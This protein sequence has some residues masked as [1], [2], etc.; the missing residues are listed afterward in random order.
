MTESVTPIV[1]WGEMNYSQHPV[2]GKSAVQNQTECTPSLTNACIVCLRLTFG[3]CIRYY[4]C[5][6]QR[7]GIF[8][9]ANSAQNNDSWNGILGHYQ[10]LNG[11][12][13]GDWE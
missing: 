2:R 10:R 5:S 3:A 12:L 4:L 1:A 7:S 13:D 8:Q 9:Q 11:A 6:C